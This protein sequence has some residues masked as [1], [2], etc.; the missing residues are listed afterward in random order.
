M[1]VVLLGPPGAGKGTQAALLV[2]KTGLTYLSTGDLFR[3]NL[4]KKT[5][6]GLKA[7]GY[8]ERGALVPDEVT[9]GMVQEQITAGTAKGFL[10]DGFPR[11]L[12]QAKALD[13]S[14]AKKGQKVDKVLLIVVDKEELIKRI[15][16]RR[17]CRQ[18]QTP[19]N[20]DAVPPK[21]AGICDRCGGELYQRKDDTRE[22]MEQ[23]LQVYEKE[24]APLIDFYKKKSVLVS[25]ESAGGIEA[26]NARM[27]KALQIAV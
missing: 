6:L 22:V 12:V 20:L 9:I 5:A 27:L 25:I 21:V 14:L 2:D 10:L 1:N 26:T 4:E 19:Y 17:V 3:R 23:R 18:C 13:E 11:N 15:I 8:M 7:R 24:T 16:G